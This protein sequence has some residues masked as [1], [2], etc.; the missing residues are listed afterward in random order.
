MIQLRNPFRHFWKGDEFQ[1]MTALGVVTVYL[2]ILTAVL[3]G[4]TLGLAVIRKLPLDPTYLPWAD[5]WLVFMQWLVPAVIVGVA[6]KRATSKADVID[7]QTR[8]ALAGIPPT[9]PG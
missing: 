1:I 3:Y 8:Q 7:A 2:L 4:G 6:T 5:R 9:Q